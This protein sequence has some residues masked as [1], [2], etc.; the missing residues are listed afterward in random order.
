M[1]MSYCRFEGTKMELDACIDDVRDHYFEIAEYEVS[2]NEIDHFRKMVR[3]F[4]EFLNELEL[5]N[6]D[7]EVDEDKLE[8]VCEMMRHRYTNEGY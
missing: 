5:L 8:E 3:N 6:D 7:N 2:G 1:Y 4:V